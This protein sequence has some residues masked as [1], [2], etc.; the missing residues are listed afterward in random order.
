LAPRATSQPPRPSALANRR[1]RWLVLLLAGIPLAASYGWWTA[2]GPLLLRPSF[3]DEDFVFAAATAIRSGGDPYAWIAG[4]YTYGKPVYIYPPLWAWLQQPLVPLG[5]EGA[6]LALLGILQLGVV[7]FLFLLYRAL[8]PVDPQE[9]VLGSLL[10]ISFVPIVANLWSDQVNLVVLALSGLLLSAYLRGDG[11]WGGAAYGVAMALKPLQPGL[12]LL[13]AWG[14]RTRMLIAVVIAG[15]V[16]SLVP[17]PHLLNLYLTRVFGSAAAATGFRDNAAPAGFLE[18]L[19][20]PATFYDGSA[21][22]DLRVRVLYGVAVLA[23]IGVTWWRLGRR[24]RV[25]PL[26]RALEV[27][28]AVA[29]SPLLLSIAHTFHLVLL[30]LPILVLLH[31]GF[32]RSDRL[33]LAAAVGGWLLVGPV[34]AA[35]LSLI[36]S[37]FGNDLVLRVW[38][39]SQLVGIVVL[40]LGCLYGLRERGSELDRHPIAGGLHLDPGRLGEASR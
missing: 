10:T 34:H 3:G 32:A 26:G 30:L 5:T 4:G 22:A 35:M 39:E 31:A 19:F 27:G 28:A 23:V 2:L 9:V 18:R 1:F 21:P 40:W 38:N 13:L 37:G 33:A 36:S 6:S 11:W 17:G 12:G 20:H 7:L 29:A 16:A 14:R 15:L 25:R 8:R 24:P